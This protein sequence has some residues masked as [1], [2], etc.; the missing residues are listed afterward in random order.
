MDALRREVHRV[1]VGQDALIDGMLVALLCGGH[2]LIEGV[3]GLAKT[4]CVTTLARAM[5]AQFRRIQFT[6]DLLPGDLVGAEVLLPGDEDFHVR[7]GPIFA[8]FILADEVNR[9]PAKVQSALLEAMQERQ[10]TIG[11]QTLP[12]PRPFFVVATANP[13]EQEGTYPLPEAEVDRFFLKLRVPYPAREEEAAIVERM[14]VA[15]PDLEVDAVIAPERLVELRR[16]ADAVYVD[17]R[18][19][20]YALDIVAQTRRPD[21]VLGLRRLIEW[22]ASPRASIC[23][24]MAAR[25]R[26]L[27]DGRDYV[28]PDD[29]KA[30]APGVL[31]HRVILTFE[32]E[33]EGISTDQV[34]RAIL[35]HVPVP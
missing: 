23:L 11:G 27:L 18:A 29:I 33:A 34:V 1:I 13:I 15:E 5:G 14:A 17:E 16:T 6:P 21:D 4:L 31:R 2:V 35:D 19:R 8:Q 9:A 10:V 22:G 32:A 25:A 7:R 26:A 12:L 28:A 3:P 30:A 20:D 24:V